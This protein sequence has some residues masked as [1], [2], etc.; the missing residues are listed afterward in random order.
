LV[1]QCDLAI[2]RAA[3]AADMYIHHSVANNSVH[4]PSCGSI[5]NDECTQQQSYS[6]DIDESNN[7]AAQ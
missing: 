2:A 1:S 3:A 4:A 6:F 7:T 5:A